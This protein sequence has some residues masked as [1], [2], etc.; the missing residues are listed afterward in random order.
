LF[1][2]PFDSLYKIAVDIIEKRLNE[3]EAI[4]I[5]EHL[6]SRSIQFILIFRNHR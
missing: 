4:E 5:F 3:R 6:I 1:N 2:V